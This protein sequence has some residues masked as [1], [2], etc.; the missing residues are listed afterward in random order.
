VRGRLRG[1]EIDVSM[2]RLGELRCDAYIM[3]LYIKWDLDDAF[4]VG[5]GIDI[6]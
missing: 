2:W 1:G 5:K 4:G 3:W 6:F